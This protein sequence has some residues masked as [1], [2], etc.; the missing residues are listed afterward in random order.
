MSRGIIMKGSNR[1][2]LAVASARKRVRLLPKAAICTAVA[3][4]TASPVAAQ[5]FTGSQT[6][7]AYT[8]NYSISTD[9]SLGILQQSDITSWTVTVTDGTNAQTFSNGGIGFI[10]HPLTSDGTNLYFDYDAFDTGLFF[11]NTMGV[12]NSQLCFQ[13]YTYCAGGSAGLNIFLSPIGGQFEVETGN[14][15]IASDLPSAVPEPST[16]AL[17]LLGFGAIGAAMRRKR[18]SERLPQL[19]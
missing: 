2:L 4:V 13:S 3:V 8:A 1:G 16:W 12:G 14:Q 10:N 5:T 7:G 19:A 18:N 17:M 11:Y 9:G 6:A 15:V